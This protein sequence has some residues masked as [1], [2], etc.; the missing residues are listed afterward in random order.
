[1]NYA[2]EEEKIKKAIKIFKEHFLLF[3]TDL[4]RYVIVAD[5][6]ISEEEY[7][8]LSDILSLNL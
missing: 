3:R 5:P 2:L 6:N 4:K 1:M 7:E 8:L